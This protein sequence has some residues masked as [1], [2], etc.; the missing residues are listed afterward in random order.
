M[1]KNRK[2][3][4]LIEL[5]V[6]IVIIGMI[7]V[8]SVP[9]IR[10]LRNNGETQ[11][12]TTY[13]EAL[14]NSAKLYVDAYD[15]D[16]FGNEGIGCNFVTFGMLSDK[17]LFKDISV[18]GVSCATENTFVRVV[19]FNDNYSYTAYLGCGKETDI[20]VKDIDVIYP[21]ASRP[22]KMDT[23]ICSGYNSISSI[24]ID[25]D[26]KNGKVYKKSYDVKLILS[27]YS[28]INSSIN[29][30]AAWSNS[31]IVDKN[32]KY[33]KIKFSIPS[34]Q[35]RSILDGKLIEA[36]S[37]NITTPANENGEYYLHVRVNNLSDLVGKEW[38]Q[39]DGSRYLV[40]G[41]FN[42]D[43]EDPEIPTVSF[44]KWKNLKN[45]PN[46]KKIEEYD[47]Y[48]VNSY[49]EVP[50]FVFATSDDLL[51][52][53]DHFEYTTS[54]RTINESNVPA[55]YRNIKANGESTIKWRACDKAGNCS[56]YSDEYTVRVSYLPEIPTSR[57]YFWRNNNNKPDDIT[58]GLVEYDGN[59]SKLNV[60]SLPVGGGKYLDHYEFKITYE[61]GTIST[62]RR[63][64][65]N[66][67][68]E[69]NSIVQW[70]T[71]NYDGLCSK[72]SEEYHTYIDRT[73]PS[74][75]EMKLYIWSGDKPTTSDGL[76]EYYNNT[77]TKSNVYVLPTNSTDSH[78]GIDHYEYTTRGTTTADTNT[79][80]S[81][82][83]IMS[84]GESSIKWRAC[85]KAG[86]CSKYSGDA[87]IKIDRT[88][89]T[90]SINNSSGGKWTNR[91]VSLYLSSKENESGIF[92]WY[93]STNPDVNEYSLVTGDEHT[94]WVM[95]PN[96][97]SLQF[98]ANNFTSE[99]NQYVYIRVCDGVGNCVIDK[100][101]V[102]ID[103]TPPKV[104]KIV[105][106]N[107]CG[108]DWGSKS[109][110][111]HLSDNLSGEDIDQNKTYFY[112]NGRFKKSLTNT[113]GHTKWTENICTNL[114]NG[115]NLKYRLCD[116]AGN[117][118]DEII[119]M[120]D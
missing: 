91:N 21:E 52:G 11:K 71:C 19:K 120:F 36:K 62:G 18:D 58:P 70:K 79:K 85:D 33:N 24:N 46:F 4:T 106:D 34:N 28:G 5:I 61:D 6:A 111:L 118:T 109:S 82:R 26:K 80:A 1:K 51:S 101:L 60:M 72:Y 116:V 15:E 100:T 7:V 67:E 8:L 95:Y 89:P 83:N 104:E 103:K 94:G 37:S 90:I 59:W 38:Q 84:K 93:Y 30:E 9:A 3:F 92:A 22:H 27:S 32:L 87:I 50:V 115:N 54:G 99:R 75:P 77:W 88:N 66:V 10:M 25:V 74:I 102:K 29:I 55:F 117:C 41:P 47:M 13:Q 20:G 56:K 14:E 98:N 23:S 108:K 12:Y 113:S 49:S 76:N 78:S 86:N 2:G 31:S 17:G 65:C 110:T 35:R 44:Y 119:M 105:Q 81:Y 114:Y 43:N 64:Y 73:P 16:L 63:A 97:N 48:E 107:P 96:S 57:L 42:I 69:G 112:I 68:V 40:F 53:I 45:M 39:Y